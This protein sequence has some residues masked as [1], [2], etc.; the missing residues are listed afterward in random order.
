[1]RLIYIYITLFCVLMSQDA[2]N[3]DGMSNHCPFSNFFLI[4]F[5][6]VCTYRFFFN[7]SMYLLRS[8]L[9]WILSCLSFPYASSDA[10]FQRHLVFSFRLF[11]HIFDSSWFTSS[12]YYAAVLHSA[13]IR[14]KISLWIIITI[15]GTIICSIRKKKR[16]IIITVLAP[17]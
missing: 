3:E 6:Y 5:M 12:M 11:Q 2:L 17:I 4:T 13:I 15:I 1:M 9:V 14:L 8:P 16:K 7:N 10:T